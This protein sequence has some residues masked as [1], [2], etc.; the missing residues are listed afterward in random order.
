LKLFAKI[1]YKEFSVE[2]LMCTDGSNSSL[3]SADL[4]LKLGFPATSK[5]TT[6]G[7]SE[8]KADVEKLGIS[9]DLLEKKLGGKYP[10]TRK[11]RN[12]NAPEEILAEALEYSYDL[13]A[14]GGGGQLGVLHSTLGTTTS[15]L[16][17]KLHT[18]FLVAR[19]VPEKI[20]KILVCAGEE[21]APSE[22]MTLGGAWIANTD[23]EIGLLHVVLM[24]KAAS[25]GDQKP[26]DLYGDK[27]ASYDLLL[28]RASR[29]LR[30]AGVGGQIIPIIRQGLVVEEVLNEL[31]DGGFKLLVVGAHYQPGQDLWQGALFD[32]VTDRLLNRSR[33]SVL[34][35]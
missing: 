32:D 4:I 8:K 16:S 7:V 23:A 31:I 6:L 3:Q 26:A 2:I 17:R 27:K 29:Q 33:C 19:N 21:S 12:G 20:D 24:E 1:L 28:E 10:I 22:T 34:I 11:I 35:I 18:H 9:M 14:V 25:V 15:E 30:D 5:I 13:V